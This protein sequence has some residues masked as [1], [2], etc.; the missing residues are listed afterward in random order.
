MEC[1]YC[2]KPIAW[3]DETFECPGC[4]KIFHKTCWEHNEYCATR[5]CGGHAKYKMKD[6]FGYGKSDKESK[7][8]IAAI[9]NNEMRSNSNFNDEIYSPG[10]NYHV[11]GKSGKICANNYIASFLYLLCFLFFI[12]IPIRDIEYTPYMTV[13][14]NKSM[15]IVQMMLNYFPKHSFQ[16]LL[17]LVLLCSTIL[18]IYNSLRGNKT[19]IIIL[20]IAS[21]VSTGLFVVINFVYYGFTT[22]QILMLLIMLINTI[23]MLITKENYKI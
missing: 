20:W 9:Y 6:S 2:Q 1:R 4:H 12:F 21:M 18:C 15:T 11:E 13:R 23:I 5:Y 22:Y 10:R 19:N 3:D 14:Y 8:A 17:L 7:L 16:A